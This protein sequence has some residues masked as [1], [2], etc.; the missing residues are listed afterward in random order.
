MYNNMSDEEFK[1]LLEKLHQFGLEDG[2]IGYAYWSKV[3]AYLKEL[4]T[5]AQAVK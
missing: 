4:R 1:N 3:I 5:I 2:D